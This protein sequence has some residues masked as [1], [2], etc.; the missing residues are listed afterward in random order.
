MWLPRYARSA[1]MRQ[2]TQ[3]DWI[4]QPRVTPPQVYR[5]PYFKETNIRTII[6]KCEEVIQNPSMTWI[7]HLRVQQLYW[8][9]LLTEFRQSCTLFHSHSNIWRHSP[10][11]KITSV[12]Q[13]IKRNSNTWNSGQFISEG[14]YYAVYIVVPGGHFTLGGRTS[15]IYYTGS[16]A[17]PT[18]LLQMTKTNSQGQK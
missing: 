7:K 12:R 5:Y 16:P 11:T 14:Q 17:G 18:N 15:D 1:S 3:H 2:E 13:H 6:S 10:A 4:L 8:A 9:L